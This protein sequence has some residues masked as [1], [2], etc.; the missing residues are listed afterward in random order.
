M[1]Q[2]VLVAGEKP[3]YSRSKWGH[4]FDNS[5]EP[6]FCHLRQA[7]E[8]NV[9]KRRP[10]CRRSRSRGTPFPDGFAREAKP[11]TIKRV[12]TA[13]DIRLKK[14]APD[15]GSGHCLL[16]GCFSGAGPS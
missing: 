13:K 11:T 1:T 8:W 4:K 6:L 14:K 5:C 16:A 2:V 12:F 3:V 15:Q 9:A 7:Q 10:R